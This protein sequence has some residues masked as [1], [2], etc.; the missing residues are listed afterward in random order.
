MPTELWGSPT[1]EDVA[2]VAGVSKSTVSRA[3]LGRDRV[4]E[5]TQQKVRAAAA[6]LGYVPNVLAAELANHTSSTVGLLLRDA[7]NPAYGLMFTRLHEEARAAGLRILSSTIRPGPE[8]RA[9]EE[10]ST[11]HWMMGLKV[12]GLIVA[13]GGVASEELRPFHAQIPIIRAGRPEPTGQVHAVS[14]DERL[15]ARALTDHVLVHGHRQVA[16]LTPPEEIS[17]PEHVRATSMTEFLRAHGAAVTVIPVDRLERGLTRTVQL[18]GDRDVSAVMC[19]SDI[20]QLEVIRV[21]DDA[22]FSV[23]EDAS[24]TGCDGIMPGLDVMGLTS[25][26]IGVEVLAERVIANLSRL[27][28]A[29]G[30][31]A[32]IEPRRALDA[33][34]TSGAQDIRSLDAPEK[35]HELIPGALIPGRTVAAPLSS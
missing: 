3:L 21:L 32:G 11:L 6:R 2:R 29:G 14:Y 15:A 1:V 9:A 34:D 26:R 5:A 25:Y 23:P 10:I 31:S 35:V 4:S 7:S 22:G 18:V 20:R 13:T 8:D 19:P 24:V 27:L 30:W 16:V 12:S 28:E 17:Y 33:R